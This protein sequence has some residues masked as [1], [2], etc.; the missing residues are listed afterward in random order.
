MIEVSADACG[1]TSRNTAR[2]TAGLAL[3]AT[4]AVVGPAAAQQGAG[5][6]QV[7]RIDDRRLG[8]QE[9]IERRL[10]WFY[11]KTPFYDHEYR[12]YPIARSVD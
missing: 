12:L 7:P 6:G 8:E 2:G 1:R 9:R 10:E 4:L 3:V 5:S 11:E